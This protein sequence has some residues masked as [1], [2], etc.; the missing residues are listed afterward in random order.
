VPNR[1]KFNIHL[2]NLF[3]FE[4]KQARSVVIIA[5]KTSEDIYLQEHLLILINLN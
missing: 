2:G 3:T 5:D 1:K 4:L